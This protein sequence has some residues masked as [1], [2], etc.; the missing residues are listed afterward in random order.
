MRH[1]RELVGAPYP[2][3]DNR[4]EAGLELADFLLR[5]GAEADVVV[6]VPSGGVAVGLPLAERLGLPFDLVLVRKLPLP[7]APEA[8]FGA[9]SASGEVALNQRLVYGWGL[10]PDVIDDVVAR[11]LDELRQREEMFLIGRQRADL[12]GRR[13]LLVDD[14]L[15]SGFTMQAAVR[16]VRRAGPRSV[17]VGVPDAP[18]G[19]I[20]AVEPLVE[21]LYCLVA[22][23]GGSFAVASFYARWHDL[24]D[25]EVLQ[26]LGPPSLAHRGE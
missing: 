9:V 26:L 16:E 21:E 13:L 2:A 6:A 4:T 14:G 1:V 20:E 24:T 25:R 15:A 22:Q 5:E 10:S 12:S 8:G 17:A 19:T 7:M 18:V 23:R 11:V 3:F